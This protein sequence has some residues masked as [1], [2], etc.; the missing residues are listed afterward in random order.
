LTI[1]LQIYC[2][3]WRW[4]YFEDRSALGEITDKR[5]LCSIPSCLCTLCTP[6]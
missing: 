1:F 4:R 3:I 6:H 2:C 5:K